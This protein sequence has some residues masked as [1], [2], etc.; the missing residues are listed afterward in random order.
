MSLTHALGCKGEEEEERKE[1]EDREER[2]E[3]EIVGKNGRG[4]REMTISHVRALSLRRN[5]DARDEAE[6]KRDQHA[7]RPLRVLQALPPPR[8]LPPVLSFLLSRASHLSLRIIIS[9]HKVFMRENFTAFL[10]LITRQ[11]LMS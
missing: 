11:P 9:F 2:E 7:N 5:L 6:K 10:S 4:R 1:R 3:R 8:Y